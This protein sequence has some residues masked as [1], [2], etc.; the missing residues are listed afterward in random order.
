MSNG[1]HGHSFRE[2]TWER[3]QASEFVDPNN[4]P[5]KFGRMF[6]REAL[7][8]GDDALFELAT[9]MKDTLPAGD[10]AAIPAG[11]T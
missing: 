8:I 3:L 11:Y 1:A 5:G 4:D 10:N 6:K 2:M 7:I 9:A